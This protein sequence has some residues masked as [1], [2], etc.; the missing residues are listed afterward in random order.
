L[1]GEIPTSIGNPPGLDFGIVR[2]LRGLYLSD[3]QLEGT[4]PSSLCALT[5]LEALFLDGNLLT[6]VIPNCFSNLTHLRQL[7]LFKN[8]LNGE[9]PTELG[10]LIQLGT[11]NEK[12]EKEGYVT[13]FFCFPLTKTKQTNNSI[14]LP[15]FFLFPRG[16]GSGRK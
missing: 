3:N 13:F 14:F 7:F 5:T 2:H 9:V 12:M 10:A 1:D 15:T 16:I 6:G 8:Q 4:I 11:E